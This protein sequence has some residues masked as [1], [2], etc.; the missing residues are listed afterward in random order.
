MT[1]TY[2]KRTEGIEGVEWE[3]RVSFDRLRSE[4]LHRL[5]TKMKEGGLG[6]M[7]LYDPGN[8]R[9]AT[10]SR[11]LR[12]FTATK[13]YRY[14]LVPAKGPPFLFELAGT[15]FRL[16]EKYTPWLRLK[17]AIIWDR[18]QAAQQE[19]IQKWVKDVK[20]ILKDESL[21]GEKVGIDTIDFA[22]YDALR[23][24]GVDVVDGRTAMD[25]AKMI[26][27]KDERELIK[28]GAG[29]LDAAYQKVKEMLKVPGV[30][31]CD[32]AAAASKLMLE[33]GI[34]DIEVIALASGSHTSPYLR[35]FTDKTVR[36]GDMVIAD[37]NAS[38]PGGYYTDW[39]RC[40]VA[41][42][43]VSER[44]KKLFRK[45]HEMLW[46]AFEAIRAG[47]STKEGIE[48]VPE[49]PDEAHDTL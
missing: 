38:G 28:M 30:R 8:I 41:G 27:T 18:S 16:R 2:A 25:N 23:A 4:R 3:E 44:Q 17:P 22:A 48:K 24:S 46:P 42:D 32:I 20:T 45:G 37:I 40:F 39:G 1:I 6:A 21:A 5:Q 13:W 12:F 15:E 31:E 10:A 19:M 36:N 14:A 35:E 34:E 49:H 47:I 11:F 9:Y 26:K 43:K 7:L 29:I 33:R